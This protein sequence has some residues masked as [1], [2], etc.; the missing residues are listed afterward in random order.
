M[1]SFSFFAM[2]MPV[3]SGSIRRLAL[4]SA[5]VFAGAVTARA[6]TCWVYTD[7]VQAPA[8]MK[9]VQKNNLAL[10]C[11]C[12]PDSTGS[13]QND[14][15]AIPIPPGG[16]TIRQLHQVWHSCFGAV[17][18][19]NP[20]AG[21][22]ERWYAFHRQFN[23]DF[24]IWRRGINFAPIESLEWCKNIPEPIGTAGG[25]YI[26]PV[27]ALNA[28]CGQGTARP[29][30]VACTNCIAFPHCL[31][32]AGGGPAACPNQPS[33]S[34]SGSGVT[35]S[36]N[37]LDQFKNVDEVSKILDSF[38]H[39]DMHVATG[40]A[41]RTPAQNCDPGNNITSGCYNLDT[42]T[43]ACAPRDPMF[44]RLHKAIDDVVRAWQNEKA[45]DVVLVIDRSGSMSEADVGSGT[46]K[47]TAA[48]NAVENF[49]DMMDTA[50]SDG[51]V[52]TIGIVSY[53]D[54]ATV[55]LPM[56]NVD[57]HLLDPGSPFENA[58]NNISA[59][60]PG[61]CTAIA[62]GLQKAVDILCPG[63]GGT[64]QGFVPAAGT[65]ARKAILVMTDGIENV[66]P[67][68]QP[69]GATGS[70][71]G[72]Q[73]FGPQFN[74][75]NLAFTQLVSIG[76][77]S[78]ADLNGPLLT[79]VA[80]RQ[81]GIYMQNPNGT[82]YDLKDF[83]GKAFGSLTSEFVATDPK[84]LLPASQA[85]TEPFE[86][87]GC[88]DSMVTFDS[89]WNLSVTPGDLSMV[90][91]A[92]NGDLVRPGDPAVENS[93]RGLWHFSRVR[94]PYHGVASGTWRGQII[95]PHRL[96]VNGFVTDAFASPKEGIALVRR[97]IHRLC[98]DGCKRVLY[99]EQGRL[100]ANSVY[101]DA[102]QLEK[103]KGLV[104]TVATV[105]VDPKFATSLTPNQW[106][107]IVYAQMGQDT[108]RTY[109]APLSRLLCGGQR[110]I[111]TD[112]R[113]KNR[114]LLFECSGI[115]AIQAVNWKVIDANGNL[116]DHAL[117]LINHG[118][119]V[120]SYG[121]TGASLQAYA[122]M[123]A[124]VPAPI[125]AVAA[126]ITNGKDEQWFAN[127]LTTSLGRLS[128]HNRKTNWKT[129]E[130]P[131][132]EV[133]MLPSDVRAGGWDKVN[134][135]VEVEYPTVGVGT[136]LA[137]HGLGAPKIVNKEQIDPRTLALEGIT[138]P[139]AKK[140]F[141]LYDD[142]T[143]GDL[144]AGNAY[145]TAELSGL[146]KIDG[147]YKLRYMFD[148]TAGGCTTHREL[149]QSFYVDVGVD[150]KSSRVAPGEPSTLP[151]G[152]RKFDV[153]MFPADASGN[154]VGPGRHTA[155]SCL[156]KN[157]CRVEPKPVDTGKGIYRVAL[158]VAPNTGSVHLDAF[159]TG[160][161]VPAACPNCPRAASI[162]VEPTAVMNYQK[163]EATI[164]LSGPAPETPEGGAVIFLASDD[165][166]IASAPET[167][168]VPAGKTSVSFP[169]TVYHVHGA[170]EEVALSATYGEHTQTA[171]L[172][173]SDPDSKNVRSVV[174]HHRAD[175]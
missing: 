140:I 122:H 47:L 48:L 60:G 55:D 169:I 166:T 49:G 58:K 64:C 18:G 16:Q 7:N 159:D 52:N 70:T 66:A 56:T 154:S 63:N 30:G 14:C 116:V 124:A 12:N 151:N 8:P 136:L 93:R 54:N 134:A 69:A 37:A 39:A 111:I 130:E 102:L 138:I 91:D 11:T 105:T 115:Q 141:P 19:S 155:V 2:T 72:T 40:I 90:V 125:G 50:R 175:D 76:F 164:T 98:P 68:L 34:C 29:A 74:Y 173:V 28:G 170:P 97:E 79:Q 44:W 123:P 43:P 75:D 95:R 77:G 163:A 26:P 108:R 84:G 131:V 135:R 35:F 82:G 132:A 110:A 174:P 4:L 41:D 104:G 156:P 152:W 24:D 36:Y 27:D 149:A 57:S 120:F 67:C 162:K 71:C 85:A 20:P 33:T 118:Y 6:Q 168:V 99:Y 21:R 53:S 106:D 153:S 114:G 23:F 145:W 9:C 150:S 143:H 133:R 139:T 146:G 147:L 112:T 3:V 10:S 31:F 88:G 172:I 165:K 13:C 51:Q 61:G 92:P 89:G 1:H 94:L 17:G 45:T 158:E 103:Q 59:T 81:G 160:F 113:T 121:L 126:R 127:V 148:L 171:N 87:N 86:Y 22:G 107:L 62:K 117:K 161:D 144:Y 100:S 83:F 137:Q 78:G 65:N 46:P 80:E 101:K 129:G 96:Y 42:F 157:S 109:D 15:T 25:G 167:V 32:K 38:F 73:C 142:G 128:P 119:P 5:L